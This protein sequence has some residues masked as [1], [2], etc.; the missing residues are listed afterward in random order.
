VPSAKRA[1]QIRAASRPSRLAVLAL[2]GALAAGSLA[3]CET[4]QEKASA[5]R[6]ESE[7]ILQARAKRQAHRKHHKHNADGTKTGPPNRKSSRRHQKG[8]G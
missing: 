5:Q 4:T 8:E 7:R 3:G 6:A 2:C 1:P